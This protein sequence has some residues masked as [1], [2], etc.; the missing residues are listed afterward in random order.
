MKTTK[1]RTVEELNLNPNAPAVTPTKVQNDKI[2]RALKK[3]S[4]TD[5]FEALINKIVSAFVALNVNP[6]AKSSIWL[7]RRLKNH[8]RAFGLAGAAVL[9]VAQDAAQAV[10]QEPAPVTAEKLADGTVQEMATVQQKPVVE[11]KAKT[12]KKG[13]KKD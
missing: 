4:I 11:P 12:T 2:G 1:F 10:V 9:I 6:Q 13:A 5:L 7:A 3:L 8:L